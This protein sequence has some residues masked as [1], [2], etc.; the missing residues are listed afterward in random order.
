MSCP[1]CRTT[2][3]VPSGDQETE[4]SQF[5]TKCELFF[6]PPFRLKGVPVGEI[7]CVDEDSNVFKATAGEHTFIV[8]QPRI[9]DHGAILEALKLASE[10]TYM[11]Y[12]SLIWEHTEGVCYLPLHVRGL[13]G[14]LHLMMFLD[15]N[16]VGFS[17]HNYWLLDEESKEVTGFPVSVGSIIA[18]GELAILDPYQ[19][20]G[21]GAL[22]GKVSEYIARHNDA[23]FIMGETF[24]EGGMLNIRLRDGWEA[25]GERRA[26]DNTM[27][28]LIG[29]QLT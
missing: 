13:T 16:V 12:P 9:A 22:Y 20:Q 14:Q 28:T 25:Y 5:C 2:L 11:R 3:V 8:K 24:K 23:A 21:L 4:E 7:V 1:V 29:K 10:Y 27:R 26:G 18:N 15:G 6:D 19:R 17:H